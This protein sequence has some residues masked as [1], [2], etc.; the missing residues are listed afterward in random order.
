MKIAI[1]G[2]GQIG[3]SMALKLREVGIKPD[4]FDVNEELCA[5]LNAKCESFD[6]V[7]YDLVVLALHIPVLLKMMNK[8]PKDNLYIDTASV[9]SQVVEK[10]KRSGLR[11]IGGHPIAGNERVGMQAW[12]PHL[13]E[14]KTFVL[15][16]GNCNEQDEKKAEEFVKI[17]GSK[18]VWTTA[19]EHDLALAYTS[20]AP[21]F[22]SVALKNV[23]KSH[24]K[25]AGPGY[26][27]MTRL[28][29]QDPKL[30]KVFVDYNGK[31]TAMVL[32]KIAAEIT[33]IADEVEK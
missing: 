13:F 2:L 31:N 21:Y 15:V 12:D 1:V 4:L 33:K 18:P 20:H 27:S 23:S 24:E 11:F 3:G 22:V 17:L 5:A 26:Q 7:G 9:K 32:R 19:E 25:F 14:N 8:L 10:A 30:A 28:S 6:G 16:K 29:K